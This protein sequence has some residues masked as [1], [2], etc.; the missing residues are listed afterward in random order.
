[1]NVPPEKKKNVLKWD[2][3]PMRIELISEDVYAEL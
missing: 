3:P 2:L 1:M